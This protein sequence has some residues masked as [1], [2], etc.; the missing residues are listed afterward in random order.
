[1][2]LMV[3][4]LGNDRTG[5]RRPLGPVSRFAR[6][7]VENRRLTIS[8]YNEHQTGFLRGQISYKSMP[9]VCPVSR[10][11]ILNV[12]MADLFRHFF[13]LLANLGLWTAK[14]SSL[15]LGRFSSLLELSSLL[16]KGSLSQLCRV[17][18]IC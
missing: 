17:G 8:M 11:L 13:F 9:F 15:D 2:M 4:R 5:L 14:C 3:Y 12:S 10:F 6:S 7:S 1:M 16:L 18:R